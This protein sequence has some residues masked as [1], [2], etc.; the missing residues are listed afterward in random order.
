MKKTTLFL[1]EEIYKDVKRLAVERDTTMQVLVNDALK[2]Y[3]KDPQE[4]YE[5]YRRRARK[6]LEEMCNAKDR[7]PVGGGWQEWEEEFERSLDQ[8]L[9]GL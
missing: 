9:P 7:I 5:A 3:V 1:D 4:D 6:A 2:R 8:N